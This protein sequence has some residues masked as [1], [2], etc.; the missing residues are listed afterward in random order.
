[1]P[2]TLIVAMV[3]ASVPCLDG[4]R[5][6]AALKHAIVAN[7]EPMVEKRAKSQYRNDVSVMNEPRDG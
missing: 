3:S 2:E 4:S 1:V 6:F 7:P 5:T